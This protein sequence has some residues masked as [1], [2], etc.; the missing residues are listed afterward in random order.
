VNT[1]FRIGI[2]VAAVIALAIICYFV[3]RLLKPK[4][5]SYQKLFE[6]HRKKYLLKNN[7]FIA[8]MVVLFF[9]SIGSVGFL[10]R[11]TLVSI[12]TLLVILLLIA[13]TNIFILKKK[14]KIIDITDRAFLSTVIGLGQVALLL[15]L[16]FI[17]LSRHSEAYQIIRYEEDDWAKLTTIHLKDGAL[18]G[19]WNIRT[20]ESANAPYG[21]SVIYHFRDGLIGFRIYDGHTSH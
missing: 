5:I 4:K 11:I 1:V 9:F 3:Y 8:W 21:D 6:Q 20:F 13:L 14:Y 18:S 12:P 17:S 19:Y 10:L 2:T 15:W 16:N 7:R